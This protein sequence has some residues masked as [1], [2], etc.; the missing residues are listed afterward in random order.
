MMQQ[1]VLQPLQHVR[2]DAAFDEFSGGSS[3]SICC[4]WLVLMSVSCKSSASPS[5]SRRVVNAGSVPALRP[6]QKLGGF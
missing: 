4:C 2:D 1:R 3:S 6:F 5:L